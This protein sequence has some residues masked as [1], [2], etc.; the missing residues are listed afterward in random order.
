MILLARRWHSGTMGVIVL[1]CSVVVVADSAPW[2][3]ADSRSP[4]AWLA[5][6]QCISVGDV[7]YSSCGPA[8]KSPKNYPDFV[9]C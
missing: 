1:G 4:C 7:S 6:S 2:P 9:T 8:F 3:P 5:H